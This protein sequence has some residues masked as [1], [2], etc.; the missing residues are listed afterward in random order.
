M[1]GPQGCLAVGSGFWYLPP[2]LPLPAPALLPVLEGVLVASFP[3]PGGTEGFSPRA[4]HA[5]QNHRCQGLATADG[6]AS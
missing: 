6:G 4:G 5:A 3:A 1:W 2:H